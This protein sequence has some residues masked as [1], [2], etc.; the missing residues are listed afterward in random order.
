M[1]HPDTLRLEHTHTGT[2]QH[3]HTA[4]KKSSVHVDLKKTKTKTSRPNQD[5]PTVQEMIVH[6][7]KMTTSP[8]NK[9]VGLLS[10]TTV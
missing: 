3:I 10:V 5:F 8:G 4:N 2:K 7:P 1:E 6:G 9:M